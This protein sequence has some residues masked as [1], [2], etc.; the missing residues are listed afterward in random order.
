MKIKKV[1]I[2]AGGLGTRFLPFTKSVA[3]EMLPIVDRPNL[4]YLIDECKK[5]GIEEVI[6]IVNNKKPEIEK[7][8]SKDEELTETLKKENKLTELKAIDSIGS[9]VKISFVYQEKPIG[10]ANALYVAKNK[11]D[12]E[13]FAVILGDDLMYNQNY[14]CLKQLLDIYNQYDCN[15]VAVQEVDKSEVS[16]YGIVGVEKE[17]KADVFQLNDLIEKPEIE[18]APSNY[19][20]IGRYVFKNSIFDYIEKLKIGKNNE[21]QLTDALKNMLVDNNKIFAKNLQGIRF[22]TG[23]KLGYAEAFIFYSCLRDDIGESVKQFI[24]KYIDKNN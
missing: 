6:L 24:K 10:L 3:K 1:I 5:S 23:S 19:A 18:K 22:D 15:V 14:P 11:I 9:S 13:D 12:G 20:I 8:Y 16:K 2:T 7:Y 21:F 17:V 4:E